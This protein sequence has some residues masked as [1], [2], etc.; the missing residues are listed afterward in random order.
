MKKDVPELFQYEKYREMV[1]KL[2]WRFWYQLPAATKMWV[3][4]EDLIADAYVYIIS[5][6]RKSYDKT[7]A[8]QSTL[9]W[10]GVSNLFLNFALKH[11][12]K[13]RF[14]WRVELDDKHSWM[15]ARDKGVSRY[16]SLEALSKV[17]SE[18]SKECRQRIQLWFGQ[19]PV[20]IKRSEKERKLYE[21]FRGLAMKNGLSVDDCRMLMSGGVWIR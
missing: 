9:L 19:E 21:E 13:K 3:S 18:A 2:A 4:P 20:K 1:A 7:R 16:N 14:G 11:Q 6:A 8:S 12:M 17:Y 15:G 10:T 5:Q